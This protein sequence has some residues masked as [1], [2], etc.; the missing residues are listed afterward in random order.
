MSKHRLSVYAPS[1]VLK[2]GHPEYIFET[3]SRMT[4]RFEIT[5]YVTEKNDFYINKYREKNIKMYVLDGGRFQDTPDY[6]FKL[7][8]KYRFFGGVVY[9]A[10]KILNYYKNLNS[11]F[12]KSSGSLVYVMEFEYLTMWILSYYFSFEKSTFVLHS[13]DFLWNKNKG[14]FVNLYKTIS[15][16]AIE[17]IINKS[18]GIAVHGE[19]IRSDILSLHNYKY[20]N[21]V[22]ISGYGYHKV[23]DIPDVDFSRKYLNINEKCDLFLLFG[24]IRRDKGFPD[25]LRFFNQ[26]IIGDAKVILA[27]AL[28]DVTISE[29]NNVIKKYKLQNN[30]I[31]KIGY[32]PENEIKY[33]F[34][35]ANC[36]ILSHQ[37]TFKSFSGPL[38]LS[39][40]YKKPVISSN[41]LQVGDI[42]KS[43]QLGYIY[44]NDI[45]FSE[46]LKS[47]NSKDNYI[48]REKV[49]FYTWDNSAKRVKAWLLS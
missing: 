17:R 29:I 34:S 46:C 7:I 21:K 38:A 39:M 8:K 13:A 36:V 1:A 30:I 9:G 37:P 35:A 5:L 43:C 49:E 18:K 33:F 19:S 20:D 28:Q 42:V 12:T 48:P 6:K 26:E 14:I 16:R 47:F 10:N 2:L 41:S 11:F 32:I 3:L 4:D 24:L 25:I 15:R 40:Q 22:F 27:G 44:N 23:Y 45:E 31:L